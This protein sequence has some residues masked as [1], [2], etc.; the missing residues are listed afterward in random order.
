MNTTGRDVRGIAPGL[1]FFATISPGVKWRLHI[2]EL[3][4]G[5]QYSG[6]FITLRQSCVNSLGIENSIMFAFFVFSLVAQPLTAQL[7]PIGMAIIIR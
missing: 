3:G 2:L 5:I 7:L 6:L 1:S 4:F